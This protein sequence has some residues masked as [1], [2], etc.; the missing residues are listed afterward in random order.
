MSPD[1]LL[2]RAEDVSADHLLAWRSLSE[3]S[4]IGNVFH[5]PD[6]LLPA[7]RHLATSGTRL[8]VVRDDAGRWMLAVP[9]E[10]R[11]PF[12]RHPVAAA[13]TL[14]HRQMP[15][16]SPL[17]HP[18]A[19]PEHWDVLLDAVAG[20]GSRW[21][22]AHLLHA[23]HAAQLQRA[24][25]R[26]GALARR[27][28]THERAMARRHED[29]DPVTRVLSGKRR[30]ELRRRFRRLG[31]QLGGEPVVR[32]LLVGDRWTPG[33]VAEAFLS[34]EASGW[35][36]PDGGAMALD[37]H[38]A[39]FFRESVDGLAARGALQ[40]WA[41]Q[42]PQGAIAAMALL[43]HD[44]HTFYWWKIAYDE[45]Y[46][47]G[48][49]GVQVAVRSLTAFA[50]SGASV[51]DTCTVPGHQLA[52]QLTEDSRTLTTLLV[53]LGTATGNAAV[54]TAPRWHEFRLRLDARLGRR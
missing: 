28:L 14:E 36:A 34:L 45:A 16:G 41:V 10:A 5:G 32:D 30:R 46:A 27:V 7:L 39:T 24:A 50:E 26:R 40:A 11:R 33:R 51:L 47:S 35:K 13:Q 18:E 31:D 53:G 49:P 38:E 22:V 54:R 9:V 12:Y 52:A 8:V 29:S 42:G 23:D 21:W 1:S 6:L 4:S 3:T 17:A 20:L 48:T 37:H 19:A 44:A 25:A 15:F 43:V 2:L